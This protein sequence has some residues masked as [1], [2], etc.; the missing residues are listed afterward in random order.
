[1]EYKTVDVSSEISNLPESRIGDMK[2][3]DWNDFYMK[4]KKPTIKELADKNDWKEFVLNYVKDLYP[5]ETAQPII[6]IL[7]IF[8]NR[9]TLNKRL[10]EMSLAKLI[11]E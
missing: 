8:E 6:K 4:T 3:N 9:G 11:E 10:K 2:I 7:K 5:K 1:M